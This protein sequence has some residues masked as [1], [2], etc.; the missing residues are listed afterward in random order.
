MKSLVL[1]FVIVPVIFCA[2]TVFG[3]QYKTGLDLK[4]GS[5]KG[6]NLFERSEFGFG[7]NLP[8]SVSWR[9]FAPYPGNQGNYSTCVGWSSGYCAMTTLHAKQF[10][11]KNR[12]VI[13]AMAMCPYTVYNGIKNK[14]DSRCQEGTMLSDAGNFLTL[15]GTK[16]FH[17]NESSCGT[18]SEDDKKI[19]LYKAAD[20][21]GLWE[22][23]L[24]LDETTSSPTEKVEK[25]KSALADGH[26]VVIGMGISTSF[27]E[28]INSKGV[29][30]K[31]KDELENMVV[32]GHAMCVLG[33]DDNRYGG[34]F[35]VQNSWG[36]DWGDGGYVY[37]SYEDFGEYVM[38]AI[39][40]EAEE[41]DQATLS[42]KGCLHGNCS[43]TYS[44][45]RF[46]NGDVYEGMAKNG[47]ANGNG[48]YQ[49]AD[50]DVYTG[51]FLDGLKEGKGTY[52][53][54][55]GTSQQGYWK[56]DE[57]RTDM[58]YLDYKFNVVEF[59]DY[60]LEGYVK[61]QDWIYGTCFSNDDFSIIYEGILSNGGEPHGFGL[62]EG[63]FK[64]TLGMFNEGTKQGLNAL[65]FNSLKK[66]LIYNCENN[67]C[68]MVSDE[69]INKKIENLPLLL[70]FEQDSVVLA[71][72]SCYFGNCEN[73]FSRLMYASKSQYEGFL[74]NGWR[75]GYGK[76][77]F[78]T[79]SEIV[80]YEGKYSFNKRNGIGRMK[81]KDGSL[82]IGE[83]LGG[84][85]DGRGL[86][87]KTDGVQAGYWDQNK[88]VEPEEEEEFGFASQ[89]TA[90]SGP[91]P[92]SPSINF[93]ERTPRLFAHPIVFK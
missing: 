86:W 6:L 84:E 20:F 90:D 44:K 3:Q 58:L 8:D 28:N 89:A 18:T 66:C 76:Y 63:I 69:S 50:G 47:K 14:Y 7:E 1:L 19:S 31:S 57:F 79:G 49:W 54:S 82:F 71:T 33:Y 36:Q 34:T 68:D 92:K 93:V 46:E 72:D 51:E 88:F 43:D 48:I 10:N 11:L 74:V 16:R 29:W 65:Y 30:E 45:F 4:G 56:K 78:P 38:Q 73:S 77:T 70:E 64:S 27:M 59:E 13:T 15:S 60:I 22:W 35:E 39:A 91:E 2:T 61:N 37:L 55:D 75:H 32:G 21:T 40:L 5:S 87:L 42:K 9:Q 67:E 81:M 17:L 24:Y 23:G 52:Y 62:L 41:L 80:S 25:T 26:I 12:N 53:Y 83:F 85:P